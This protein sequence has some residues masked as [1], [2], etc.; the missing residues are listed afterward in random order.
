MSAFALAGTVTFGLGVIVYYAIRVIERPSLIVTTVLVLSACMAG[1][2]TQTGAEFLVAFLLSLMNAGVLALLII[3]LLRD[4]L[5]AYVFYGL[6]LG[7][8]QSGYL[9]LNQSALLFQIH[10]WITVSLIL[11]LALGTWAWAMRKSAGT[12]P[13]HGAQRQ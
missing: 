8:V 4:N 10:G 2:S 3:F 11:G 7:G 12:G 5:L 1:A 9:M 13:A 6:F